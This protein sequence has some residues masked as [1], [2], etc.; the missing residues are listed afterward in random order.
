[1]ADST[2]ERYFKLLGKRKLSRSK[3]VLRVTD[4]PELD[5]ETASAASSSFLQSA[6]IDMFH[7]GDMNM[8]NISFHHPNEVT[9]VKCMP[10]FHP[11]QSGVKLSSP[12]LRAN[13]LRVSRIA[14]K[15]TIVVLIK[16]SAFSLRAAA[17]VLHTARVCES[18]GHSERSMFPR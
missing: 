5:D 12:V 13:V 7:P 9:T 2:R 18:A 4:R 14:A 6:V 11:G 15:H 1:M 10:D 17:V 8:T 16:K 3:N